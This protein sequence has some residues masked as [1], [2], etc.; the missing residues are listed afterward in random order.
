MIKSILVLATGGQADLATFAAALGVAREF[1]AHIEFLHVHLNAVETAAAMTSD[2]SGGMLLGDLIEQLE[3]DAREREAKAKRM[4]DEFCARESV[5]ISETPADQPR[6]PT[7]QWHVENGDEARWIT[8]YGMAADLIIA[9]RGT[10]DEVAAHSVLEAALLDTGRPLM[11]SGAAMP[12]VS[13]ATVA[14]AWKA[15]PQAAR[16]VAAA[17]PFIAR[18]K[19]IIVLT[20]EEGQGTDDADRLVR[21]LAWHGCHASAERLTANGRDGA[22]LLL[23]AAKERAGLLVMGGYGHSRLREWVF[24]GFTQRVLAEASLPVLMAH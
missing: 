21:N 24:G 18:A 10:E 16:A 9:R 13:F 15:T 7:A 11:I 1:C 22:D 20:V 3:K 23:D 6:G 14:I 19:E 4:F 2:A 5:A 12:A 17:M 8:E